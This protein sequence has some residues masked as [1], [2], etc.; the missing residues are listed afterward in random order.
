MV[1]TDVNGCEVEA[2]IFDVVAGVQTLVNGRLSLV[3]YPNP[4]KNKFTV[5][6]AE[7]TIKSTAH[8]VLWTKEISIYNM[9]GK[10]IS[11]HSLQYPASTLPVEIDVSSLASGMYWIELITQEKA[12]RLKFIKE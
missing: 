12:L 10:N 9:Q 3:I 4:V 8:E 2:V 11:G 5:H 6:N 1:C 7:C